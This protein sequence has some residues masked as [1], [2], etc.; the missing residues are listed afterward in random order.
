M[1]SEISPHPR[2]AFA[3]RCACCAG[4][5]ALVLAFAG[6]LLWAWFSS[7]ADDYKVDGVPF[8]EW[9]AQRPD[10]MIQEPLAAL[11]T[12]ALPHLIRIVRR[13]PESPRVYEIKQKIWNSL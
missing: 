2:R 7:G 4:C 3:R 12:N 1:S 9:V 6:F 11:G 5:I 10:F 13:Q 8:R